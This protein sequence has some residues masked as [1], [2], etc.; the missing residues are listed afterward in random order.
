[1]G[2]WPKD[3]QAPGQHDPT[4]YYGLPR[5]F[6]L[7]VGNGTP[8][9]DNYEEGKGELWGDIC[10]GGMSDQKETK[11]NIRKPLV[12]LLH[13]NKGSAL[14]PKYGW[15]T[16]LHYLY[17][18]GYTRAEVWAISYLGKTEAKDGNEPLTPGYTHNIEDVRQ[19]IDRV[20]KYVG[21][22][23]A[24]PTFDQLVYD[25]TEKGKVVLI[26]HS[27]GAG[28]AKGYLLGMKYSNCSSCDAEFDPQLERL[29][30]VKAVITLAGG[31][32]GLQGRGATMPPNHF[33][34]EWAH[35]NLNHPE[36]TP[37]GPLKAN[38]DILDVHNALSPKEE[39]K[40][41]NRWVSDTAGNPSIPAD[42]QDKSEINYAGI[43]SVEDAVDVWGDTP[44]LGLGDKDIR[45]SHL[46]G[47]NMNIFWDAG[48]ASLAGDWDTKC[49]IP[50]YVYDISALT[51]RHHRIVMHPEII[52]ILISS[53]FF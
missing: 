52:D 32:Y 27:L 13:G 20:R 37:R 43:T 40:Y 11:N 31:N 12:I 8:L 45:S 24:A 30:A 1:V 48:K 44:L 25:R 9:R 3:D 14:H 15:S 28:M 36:A 16:F 10:V 2:D 7:I 29:D 42:K 23:P 17:K 18:A 41:K 34:E 50:K 47:A 33:T 46:D 21:I 39:E 35:D 19:F 53:G 6:D 38:Q 4:V 49:S 51:C 5:D 22:D 26:G